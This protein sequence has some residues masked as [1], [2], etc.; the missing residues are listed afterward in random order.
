MVQSE[1]RR[2]NENLKELI[3]TLTDAKEWEISRRL[4]EKSIEAFINDEVFSGIDTVFL[5]GH[6]TSYAS[7]LTAETFFGRIAGVHAHCMTAY[8]FRKCM[9]DYL[10]EPAHTLVLGFSTG[11][12]TESVVDCV[13]EARRRGAVGIGAA[14]EKDSALAS[15]GNYR[16]VSSVDEDHDR[17]G[18]EFGGA[19]TVS[20]IYAMMAAY[21]LAIRLGQRRGSLDSGQ[22]A[23]WLR[24]LDDIILLTSS[25]ITSIFDTMWDVTADIM[26]M[27]AAT[28]VVIG[29]GPNIGTAEEAALKVAEFT[30]D[31]CVA[32]D[33]ED[34]HHGRF[35]ELDERN[36]IFIIAPGEV[37]RPK[38]LDILTGAKY[39]SSPTVVLTEL[40]CPAYDKL[41]DVVI[42][43]P[44]VEEELL[45]PFLYIF[46]FWAYGHIRGSRMGALVGERRYGLWARDINFKLHYNEVGDPLPVAEPY[47]K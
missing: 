5:V 6:G 9:D 21:L 26:R 20:H 30:W 10:H 12:N 33:L 38:A 31:L 8:H 34:L 28:A 24:Q 43:M 3:F 40:D 17:P 47:Y 22:A 25:S 7:A 2:Q 18:K 39:S 19:Y 44:H 36:V 15:A 32:E 45:T 35:R 29:A 11:G 27:R 37:D 4:S 41:A 14:G 13:R 23:Y 16:L 42:R 1:I 46:P